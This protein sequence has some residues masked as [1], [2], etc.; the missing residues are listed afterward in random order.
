MHTHTQ[1]ERDI[2]VVSSSVASFTSIFPFCF[3]NAGA[4]GMGQWDRCGTVF[5][6][7]CCF[8]F[9]ILPFAFVAR[10]ALSV[11]VLFPI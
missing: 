3:L 10:F 4:G 6:V 11:Y 5:Y 8:D 2:V 7:C 1:I 9:I